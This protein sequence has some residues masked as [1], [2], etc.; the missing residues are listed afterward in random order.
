MNWHRSAAALD[1][2]LRNLLKLPEP[3]PEQVEELPP[4]PTDR[5]LWDHYIL[6]KEETFA[7]PYSLVPAII[8]RGGYLNQQ[9]ACLTSSIATQKGVAVGKFALSIRKFYRKACEILN[10]DYLMLEGEKKTKMEALVD[11]IRE[12]YRQKA[13]EY[14]FYDRR[15]GGSIYGGC[16]ANK[17]NH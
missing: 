15:N 12:R 17:G 5:E 6:G 16:A 2:K 11:Q 10:N 8:P 13:K 9:Y 7:G 4:Q 14:R 3:E 1:N